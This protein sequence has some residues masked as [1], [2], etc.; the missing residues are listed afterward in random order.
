MYAIEFTES[1]TLGSTGLI[2]LLKY[3]TIQIRVYATEGN[4]VPTLD[5]FDRLQKYKTI[6]IQGQNGAPILGSFK[7]INLKVHVAAGIRAVIHFTI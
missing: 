6:Q 5:S 3:K 7:N 2:L 4:G 1:L